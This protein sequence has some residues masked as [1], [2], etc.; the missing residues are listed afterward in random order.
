[1]ESKKSNKALTNEM[2]DEKKFN[3]D[4]LESSGKESQ[5]RK[6][7]IQRESERKKELK[8]KESSDSLES[9]SAGSIIDDVNLSRLNNIKKK[10]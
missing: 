1:M 2:E 5:R 10:K 3:S 7:I 6:K 8:K 4:S 9:K